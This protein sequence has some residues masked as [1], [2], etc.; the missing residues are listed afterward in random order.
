ML[1]LGRSVLTQLTTSSSASP[2]FQLHRLLS[3]AAPRISPNPSFCAKDYLV[4]TCGLTPAQA[5]KASTKL[6]HLKCP[7][8]SD[9]VLAFLAGLGLSSAAVAAAVAKDPRLLCAKV[10]KTLAPVVAGLTGHGL[11]HTE[12]ARLVSLAPHQFRIASIVSKVQYYLP[13]FGSYENLLR[14]LKRNNRLLFCSLE[15]VVEPNVV[16]LR[17]CGI[18]G[19]D[20]AKLCIS[21]PSMITENPERV[22]AMAALVEGLG[23]PRGSGMFRHMLRAV[24]FNKS[25][26]KIAV[27]MEY[28]KKTFRWSDAE[29]RIAVSRL[30][31]VLLKSK[32]SLQRMSK[33]L[34]SEV[35]L[36]PARIAH[37]AVI[38]SL[39]L[40]GR[41][42][43]RYYVVMF[44]KENRL[45]DHGWSYC[46]TF[47]A[48]EKVFV[49]KFICPHKEAAP[50]LA[51]DYAAACK[52]Q[53]PT[54]F[55]FS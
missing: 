19:F 23:V 1:R 20:I 51:E 6:S 46:T 10:E 12:V 13:L 7:T 43:P 15:G 29:V 5:L 16:F 25:E 45:I 49:E 27:K 14:V 42:K 36:E 55:I 11:S 26:E 39:S 47:Q 17:D 3:A 32:D 53:I 28:L 8:N 50:H 24:A 38:V 54:R 21:V 40:E 37:R 31:T 44:L 52:G 18:Y 30:P 22:Q 33:F 2:V 35:G 9:A 41:L 48:T 4:G 34:I